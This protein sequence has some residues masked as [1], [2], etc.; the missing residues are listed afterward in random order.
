MTANLLTL[1]SF[2]TEFL[3]TWLKKTNLPKYTTL[4]LTP[5]TL[6]QILALS[7]RLSYLLWPNYISLQ[8]LL[9]SRSSTS[10]CSALH[11]FVN[12]MYHCYQYPYRPLQTW[13]LQ[14]SLLINS[15]SLN[16]LVSSRVRTLL[17]VLSS[18][19]LSPVISLPSY[20]LSTGSGSLNASSTSLSTLRCLPT[21]FSQLP[22]VGGV[23]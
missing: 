11:R 17:L 16:Y 6:L 18:K 19:L 4:H 2:K 23:A 21:K 8:S 22:L 20:A 15:L 14:F 9:L 13:L 7:W 5:P 12:S 3:I 1:N 10:L